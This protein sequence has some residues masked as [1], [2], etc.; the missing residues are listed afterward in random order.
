MWRQLCFGRTS[1]QGILL[2]GSERQGQSLIN[3]LIE[4][5]Y[6]PKVMVSIMREF[7]FLLRHLPVGDWM[8]GDG[9]VSVPSARRS[10]AD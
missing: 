7:Q 9:L 2:L 8:T 10:G 4:R 3:A 5:G 6:S 1:M